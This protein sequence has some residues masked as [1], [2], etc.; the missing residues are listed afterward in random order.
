MNRPSIFNGH[1]ILGPGPA[2]VHLLVFPCFAVVGYLVIFIRNGSTGRY[3]SSLRGS[4]TAA[5]SIGINGTRQRILLFALS[6]SIAGLGGGLI[7]LHSGRVDALTYPALFGVAWVVLVVSL[8]SRTVDGALNAAIGFVVFQWLLSDYFHMSASI[9]LIGFGF[10]AITYA[11]HPEGIVEYQTRR[12]VLATQ[13][14]RVL[15]QRAG[16]DARTDAAS[17]G[18]C[19]ASR[20]SR[21]R[22]SRARCSR[23]C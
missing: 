6:A 11:W 14:G 5:A 10:G 1:S 22:C 16:R 12:S 19:R 7:A 23:S 15:K 2:V 18:I 9:A 21:C 8:G 20:R 3:F 4:E 17:Q 13:K